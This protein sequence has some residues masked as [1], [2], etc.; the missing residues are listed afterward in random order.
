MTANPHPH[1]H[2][3]SHGHSHSHDVETN[4]EGSINSSGE[5]D[6]LH[7]FLQAHF[8]DVTLHP[9]GSGDDELSMTIK[10]DSH[11]AKLDLI[12]MKVESDAADLRARV[13]GVVE[14]ALATMRPL[15]LAFVGGGVPVLSAKGD[16]GM[17]VESATVAAA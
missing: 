6:N 7:M 5:F 2:S 12:S 8:G 14:M 17:K 13:E 16:E 1:S 11:V 4:G 15:S 9:A 3:H 10:V